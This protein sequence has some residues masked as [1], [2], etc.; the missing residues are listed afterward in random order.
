[1]PVHL[2]GIQSFQTL[3]QSIQPRISGG[4]VAHMHFCEGQQNHNKPMSTPNA[5]ISK[6]LAVDLHSLYIHTSNSTVCGLGKRLEAATGH[7]FD[8]PARSV[9]RHPEHPEFKHTQ[10]RKVRP[11]SPAGNSR[12]RHASPRAMN[13]LGT[14]CTS[15]SDSMTMSI[16]PTQTGH[17]WSC[18]VHTC[19]LA[20]HCPEELFLDTGGTQ[21]R[22]TRIDQALSSH[23]SRQKQIL[24]THPGPV[25]PSLSRTLQME[26]IFMTIMQHT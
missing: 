8:T 7:K 15:H 11:F 21:K 3:Q 4:L 19:S 24:P 1:M 23:L 25:F 14:Q 26:M 6:D 16:E 18:C 2:R 20:Q 13:H 22:S 12:C 9:T 5:T 17:A 10:A